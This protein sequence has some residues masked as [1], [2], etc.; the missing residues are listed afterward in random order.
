MAEIFDFLF[1]QYS[2]YS[3][4]FIILEFI[5][6][7]FGIVSVVYSKNNNILVYPAGL[8]S[9]LIYV[10]LL[11]KW[12]LYG[13]MIINAYYFIMSVYGWYLWSKK[14]AGEVA[15]LKI[16]RMNAKDYLISAAIFVFSFIFV[17][18]VYLYDNKFTYWWAYV[19]TFISGLFFVG[20]WLMAKR[21]I[22]NW[23]FLIIGDIIAVPL[24]FLKG[25]TLT[26]IL[27]IVL[28]IIAV[29]GYLAWKR[30]LVQENQL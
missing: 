4:L 12:D 13:D 26:S 6:M 1:G 10:Y 25:Y 3:T 23:I 18:G 19:D 17:S 5:A 27:N 21:K 7:S 24:F 14:G 16:S 15:I 29:Y 30:K 11:Y 8:V 28:T 20:M 2:D 22:E 9:T